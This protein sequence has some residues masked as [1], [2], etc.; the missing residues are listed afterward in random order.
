MG[1]IPRVAAWRR[2]GGSELGGD[3]FADNGRTVFSQPS[4]GCG[5]VIRHEVRIDFGPSRGQQTSG[6]KNIFK[7]HWHTRQQT[8]GF[9]PLQLC[10]AVLG[11]R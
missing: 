2:V 5:I 6:V 9:A 1:G 4:D 11:R 8:G 7:P 3:R 10:F